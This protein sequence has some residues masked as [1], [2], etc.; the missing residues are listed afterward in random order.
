MLSLGVAITIAGVVFC[1]GFLI[2]V[3]VLF[4]VRRYFSSTGGGAQKNVEARDVEVAAANV[5][6]KQEMEWDNSA[7]NITVNPLDDFVDDS[8]SL[9]A[10]RDLNVDSDAH[11]ACDSSEDETEMP[12]CK[13]LEWDDSTLSF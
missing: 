3:G 6:E 5:D 9:V 11:G 12:I 2:A 8:L 4:G 1:I 13:E 10:G 7:L